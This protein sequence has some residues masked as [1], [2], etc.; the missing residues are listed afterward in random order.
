MK[1]GID[2]REAGGEK[3]GKGYYTFNLVQSLLTLDTKNHYILYTKD[4]I[5]GFEQYKNAEMRQVAAKSFFWHRKV[6]KDA[7]KEKVDIFFSPT[8]YIIPAILK[9]EIKSIFT[10]HDL[11]AFLH[12]KS[13]NK[14]ATIIE[15]FYLKKALKKAWKVLAVSQNTK[16]DLLKKFS[17]AEDKVE[18]IYPAASQN[19][20]PLDK[21]KLYDFIVKTALPKNFF[22]SVGTLLPRKNYIRLIE[23]F[24]IFFYKNPGWH[25]IIVGQKTRHYNEIL[26]KI[27]EQRLDGHV[28][29]LGYLTENSLQNLYNLSQALIFPSLYE[30]FG[31]PLVEAMQCGCPVLASNTS[32]IPEVV[33]DAA[34][35][36]DPKDTVEIAHKM[37]K[38]ASDQ[39]LCETLHF[40]GLKQSQKFSWQAAAKSF[41][42]LLAYGRQL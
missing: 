25:L 38:A 4:K 12:A 15:R 37:Q 30:G 34:L 5:P 17:F 32:S 39:S 23:A 41:Y 36:F 22:L 19:F 16:R 10:V 2:I 11:V 33:V 9:K 20:K 42:N 26:A 14:K 40:Q 18:V 27:K 7:A 13:H 31:I 6:A 24:K 29:I 1:I 35:L 28:H 3:A 8:S 21:T